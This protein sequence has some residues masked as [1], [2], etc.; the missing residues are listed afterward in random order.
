MI[1]LIAHALNMLPLDCALWIVT[2]A[3]I[4][5]DVIAGTVKAIITKTVDSQKAREGVLHKCGF[6]LALALCT[7]IDIAQH[8][9]DIGFSVPVLAGCAT[10]IILCEIYSLCEHVQ[11]C[12]PGID[13]SVLKKMKGGDNGKIEGD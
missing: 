3:F 1:D 2:L 5:L 8:V 7:F 10:M 11:E 6:I 12:T 9:A 13:I 4:A